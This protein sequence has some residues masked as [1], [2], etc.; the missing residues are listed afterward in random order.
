MHFLA[1][2]SQDCDGNSGGGG[3]SGV[4]VNEKKFGKHLNKLMK[5]AAPPISSDH[6][7]NSGGGGSCGVGVNKKKFGKNL[8]NL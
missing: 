1:T 3:S 6:D 5:L 2:K 7:G 4:G 8:N